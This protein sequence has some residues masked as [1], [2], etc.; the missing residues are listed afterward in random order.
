MM[1]KGV[2][3]K[4]DNFRDIV[5]PFESES[6]LQAG[7]EETAVG[8]LGLARRQHS[9]ARHRRCTLSSHGSRFSR[10][11]APAPQRTEIFFLR[12]GCPQRAPASLTPAA[13]SHIPS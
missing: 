7:D 6:I 13:R 5:I 9:Q 1:M 8:I 3:K 12:S 10:A 11:R 2:T 4:A